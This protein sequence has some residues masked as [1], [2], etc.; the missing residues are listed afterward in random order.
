[1]D[2]K[3]FSAKDIVF[4]ETVS[5]RVRY[6][7]T[8]RMGIVFNANYLSWFEVARTELCRMLGRAYKEWEELGYALPVAEAGCRYRSP[9]RYDDIVRIEC[10]AP[11][12]EIKPWSILFAYRVKHDDGASIADGW[13]RHALLGKDGKVS[14]HQNEFYL[15]LK[16]RCLDL[17]RSRLQSC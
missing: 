10:G 13:T 12:D 8:D 17:E 2:M 15:W 1:M 14:R 4:F 5:M 7:E 6:C 16:E 11:I 3:I 9:A